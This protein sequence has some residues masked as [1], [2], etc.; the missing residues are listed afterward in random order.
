[1]SATVVENPPQFSSTRRIPLK[2]AASINLSVLA[3]STD[4]DYVFDYVDISAVSPD[5]GIVRRETSTFA[6]APSRARRLVAQG[7]TIVS[8]VRTY[9]RAVGLV[10]NPEHLVVSTG[11]AVLTP[12]AGVHPRYLY[13]AVQSKPFIDSVVARSTG[14][15][16]PAISPA[17]LACIPVHLPNVATQ[18]A[19]ADFLDRETERI[20]ELV[21]KKQR[22]IELLQEKRSALIGHAVTKGLDPDAPMKDSGTAWFGA[23]PAHWPVVRLGHFAHV[24]NGSTPS[25]DNAA[26]W[27]GGTVPWVT[28]T[29]VNE[30][31][32]TEP[33]E[34]ITEGALRENS[35]P[36]VPA[37]TVIIGLVGQGR[38]RGMAALLGIEATINQNTAAIIPRGRIVG[39]YLQYQLENMYTPI[40]EY[41][42]GANQAALNCEVVAA[43]RLPLPPPD[44]QAAIARFL[45]GEAEAAHALTHKTRK[46]IDLLMESRSA[47]ITAAVTG[48]IDVQQYA[49]AAS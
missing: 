1:M 18:R 39:R 31:R 41:G 10:E 20:D 33:S 11:F 27:V 4:P 44:E 6:T 13:R 21:A 30:D 2:H 42:R 7:D 25:R 37:G 32:V 24:L 22:L 16:Y 47:L 34:L 26:Y 28:S 29:K 8:T 36:L 12:K 3:E 23:I 38:T 35:L 45:D 43:L 40:R 49:K 5:R 48:Q 9:L 46:S 17:D 14:V 15:S 19:I